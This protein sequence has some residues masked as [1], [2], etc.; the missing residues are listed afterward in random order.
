MIERANAAWVKDLIGGTQYMVSATTDG[1]GPW[2]APV[3]PVVDEDVNFYFFS[4]LDAR[5]SRHIDSGGQVAAVMFGSEQP[6][7]TPTLTANLNA[8][9]MTGE[10]RRLDQSEH[11]EAVKGAICFL[12][13]PMLPYEVHVFTPDRFYVPAIENGVNSRYEVTM[14]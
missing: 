11:N 3:E 8:V 7:H 6:D 12:K 5:H 9:Q 10:A 2:V 4:T 14:A 13:P 1:D